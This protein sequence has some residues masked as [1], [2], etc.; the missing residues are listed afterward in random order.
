MVIPNASD[1]EVFRN[2]GKVNFEL[3]VE[4]KN[5]S[6]FLYAG[7]LGFMDHGRL[8]ID[9]M[10][11]ISNP[12]ICLVILGDG[13][14]RRELEMLSQKANLA[15]VHFLGLLPKYRV[16]GWMCASTATLIVFKN[17]PVLQTSSPNK[18]FDSFAAR[19]PVIH[20]TTG[21]ICDLVQKEECGISVGP[22]DAEGLAAAMQKLETDK[23]LRNRLALNAGR[24]ADTL[25]N[26]DVLADKYLARLMLI[27]Q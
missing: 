5:K 17:F 16:A 7:S 3:P 20:N 26:R 2:P 11:K 23:A 25:F 27:Q 18:M 22:D 10:R 19:V 12:E 6:V 9:A 13:A 15:N 4:F 21:W 24:L 1:Q 14:E 8:M